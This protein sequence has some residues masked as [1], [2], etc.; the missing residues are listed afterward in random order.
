LANAEQALKNTPAFEVKNVQLPV[1]FQTLSQAQTQVQLFEQAHN[2]AHEHIAHYAELSPRLQGILQSGKDITHA[3]YDVAQQHI[4]KCR[5]QLQ[6]VFQDVDVLLTPSAQGEAPDNLSN[7]GDPVFCRIWTVLH[8]P[9]INVPTGLGATGMPVGLQVAGPVGSDA[10][11]L[12]AA[13]AVHQH[14]S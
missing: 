5:L 9:A 7:T 2:L 12:A 10:L 3:Q 1:D 4:A 13:H 11:T 14:I 8:T 6:S